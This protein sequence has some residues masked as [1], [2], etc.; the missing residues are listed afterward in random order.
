MSVNMTRNLLHT[1]GPEAR[2]FNVNKTKRVFGNVCTRLEY[3][4]FSLI[5]LLQDS[6]LKY[7]VYYFAVS[8]IGYYV[9]QLFYCL[10]LLDITNRFSTLRSVIQSVTQ[11]KTQLLMT[12]CLSILVLYI[13]SLVGFFYLQDTFWDSN[14]NKYDSDEF[15]VG[16]NFCQ[17]MVQCFLGLVNSG[18]RQGGGI[19]DITKPITYTDKW[20]YFTKLAFDSSFHIF[21][22]VI[23]LNIFFGI[24]IDTFAQLRDQKKRIDF[25]MRNKCYICNIDRNVVSPSIR[26]EA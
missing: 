3:Y 15:N 5:F 19:G 14:I 2:E 24:I 26:S 13:Y 17:D 10:H 18:L 22:I 25:D 23:L 1:R 20:K 8:F 9:D 4:A 21:I 11:N 7:Y 12:V 16:E 6:W